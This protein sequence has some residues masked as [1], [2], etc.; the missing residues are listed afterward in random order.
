MT[1][2]RRHIYKKSVN[3]TRRHNKVT[4][5]KKKKFIQDI[6]KEWKKQTYG[7]CERD[8]KTIYIDDYYLS[9]NNKDNFYNHIHLILKNFKNNHN[10]NNIIYVMKKY[11]T[12]LS[13]IIHSKVI[14]ISIFSDTEKVVSNM[15]KKYKEF[16]N[17]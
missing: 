17:I 15:I 1:K 4:F 6:L 9:F 16:Y 12:K 2:S 5:L 7:H 13:K 14:E 11:D 8:K 10:S 3:K